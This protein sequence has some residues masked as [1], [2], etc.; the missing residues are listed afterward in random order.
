[1]ASATLSLESPSQNQILLSWFEVKSNE[2]SQT[3]LKKLQDKRAKTKTEGLN[4]S[5]YTRGQESILLG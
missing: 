3:E 1:M 4:L 5:L 2:L